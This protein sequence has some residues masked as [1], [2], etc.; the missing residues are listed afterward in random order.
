MISRFK[1]P[2]KFDPE[3]LRSDL[4]RIC[5]D[6]WV[7]HFNQ[8]YF[9]G[10]WTGVALRSKGGDARKLHSHS[11]AELS[12][13][14]TPLLERCPY[15]RETLSR[16]QCTLQSVRFLKLAAGS[17]IKEHR[18]YD[19]GFAEGQLRL[20]IPVIT[21]PDVHFFL[22]A[23]RVELQPGECWY[24]DL[25]LPHWVENRGASDRIHLVID[26]E[27]NEWLR[28]FLPPNSS[29]ETEANESD[30]NSS[31]PEELQ[32]FRQRVLK[33][34][35]LQRRLRETDDRESF[36]RLL[37]D[38]GRQHGYRFSAADADDALRAE[39]RAWIERWID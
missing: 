14:D 33:D 31:S 34:L 26:C 37:V 12:F 38:V 28:G 16:F 11:I 4:D 2:F 35:H 36:I 10:A 5:A 30:K 32:R 24:L 27:L 17:Q 8:D 1:L 9:E 18:D 6:E 13:A 29:I 3:A 20:H 7:T 23:H 21:N 15:V 39:Q 19:L 22:D 25:S